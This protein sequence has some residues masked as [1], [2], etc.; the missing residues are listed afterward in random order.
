MTIL[1]FVGVVLFAIGWVALPLVPA[2]R[3]FFQ[4][5]DV[6]PLSM[7]SRDN[8]DIS[9]FARHFREYLDGHLARLPGEVAPDGVL[10]LPD[11]AEVVRVSQPPDMM[12]VRSLPAG[13][14]HRIVLL[15]GAAEL[16]GGEMFRLEVRAME[17]FAGGSGATYRALL[18]ERSVSLGIR[19]RVMRWVHGVG[20]LT[21][22]DQSHLYGRSSS[23]QQI[24]LGRG[25]GFDRLGAPVI[26][27]GSGAAAPMPSLPGQMLPFEVP[28]KKARRLGDILRVQ[29][30]LTI[31]AGTLV[32]G[33]LVVA[34]ALRLEAATRVRGSVKA[35]GR[36]VLASGVVIEGSLVSREEIEIGDHGWIR[37]PVISE[38]ALHVGPETTIGR[39]DLPSTASGRTV[40]LADGAAVCGQVVTQEGGQTLE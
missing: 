25:V 4:P 13:S 3:E 30:D 22:G 15:D 11:G 19:S 5:T 26:A 40:S 16:D 2:L 24:R 14:G 28:E 29:G 34:G 38:E 18:G 27:V 8:A 9:R 23:D 10:Q 37:G 32:E 35:H 6:E 33:N 7:V 36:I 20:A 39:L 12:P 17:E 21:V 1:T 31:P